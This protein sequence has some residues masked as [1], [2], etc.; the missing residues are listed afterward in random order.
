M[1][2]L[3]TIVTGGIPAN[4]KWVLSNL[5][6]NAEFPEPVDINDVT[7]TTEQELMEE[8]TWILSSLDDYH[9]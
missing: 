4:E 2:A 1:N 6:A 3:S 9:V 8:V 7:R 5:S